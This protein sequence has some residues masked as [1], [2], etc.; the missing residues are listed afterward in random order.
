MNFAKGPCPDNLISDC[1]SIQGVVNFQRGTVKGIRGAEN[2]SVL[3][4]Y[5]N[6]TSDD[7]RPTLS[8][9]DG[10]FLACDHQRP[11]P[12]VVEWKEMISFAKPVPINVTV[13]GG[14]VRFG[15]NGFRAA[16]T[17][18]L[19][20]F[21][22]D[23]HIKLDNGAGSAPVT[24]MVG[25][26]PIIWQK[27]TWYGFRL[28]IDWSETLGAPYNVLMIDRG[29]GFEQVATVE[30]YCS[31]CKYFN[32]IYFYNYD[33]DMIT[34]YDSVRLA[35]AHNMTVKMEVDDTNTSA[36]YSLIYTQG[37]L[38]YAAKTPQSDGCSLNASDLSK[39]ETLVRSTST[40][41]VLNR[42][43]HFILRACAFSNG[44]NTTWGSSRVIYSVGYNAAAKP[45][46]ITDNSATSFHSPG[47]AQYGRYYVDVSSLADNQRVLYALTSRF[48]S[49]TDD[50][51][52][53]FS[54][55]GTSTCEGTKRLKCTGG[56]HSFALEEETMCVKENL[57]M[58]AQ[59][60][61]SGR[62][63]SRPFVSNHLKVRI[64]PPEF[65]Y[66]E[67]VFTHA[68]SVKVKLSSASPGSY[69]VYTIGDKTQDPPT[70]GM[71]MPSY[72]DQID[73]ISVVS[74]V[75]PERGIIHFAGNETRVGKHQLC[76]DEDKF[77]ATVGH[78]ILDPQGQSL[79]AVACRDGNEASANESVFLYIME[80]QVYVL[81]VMAVWFAFFFLIIFIST[82]LGFRSK[83]VAFDERYCNSCGA[84]WCEFL[85]NKIEQFVCSL[86]GPDDDERAN[87]DD[88]DLA[89]FNKWKKA[90]SLKNEQ[91]IPGHQSEEE[92]KLI[93]E[94]SEGGLSTDDIGLDGLEMGPTTSAFSVAS[95]IVDRIKYEVQGNS[96]E[97]F[98]KEMAPH[99]EKGGRIS[100]PDAEQMM[101]ALL[102]P[103]TRLNTKQKAAFDKLHKPLGLSDE[104]FAKFVRTTIESCGSPAPVQDTR[105]A[106]EFCGITDYQYDDYRSPAK[107]SSNLGRTPSSAV[108]DYSEEKGTTTL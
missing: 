58:L 66:P 43:A 11:D 56:D 57:Y 79:T 94:F 100:Q 97:I 69:I 40:E 86:C 88:D 18:A 30:A 48:N 34:Y 47:V 25:G 81:G 9:A 28:Y 17:V 70:C 19:V 22:D 41:V 76:G 82:I 49:Y 13:K 5:K 8:E 74:G 96:Q 6:G 53:Y 55:S 101:Q 20:Y 45:P 67:V 64:Y 103:G 95:K 1:E 12:F 35:D 4:V 60:F 26:K 89:T 75:W 27:D 36:S 3:M 7:A 84:I 107:A 2:N 46:V 90:A 10:A 65:T 32:R 44:T 31:Y 21:D 93:G 85:Y 87:L 42:N 51:A 108:S 83:I 92:K 105:E 50:A 23:Q 16:Q 104:D 15:L 39:G 37:N 14:Y 106:L 63:P 99:L 98:D 24:A 33:A 52:S 80:T 54:S 72:D 59:S 62:W 68:G 29:S 38:S 102:K 78:V 91:L 71:D 77:G 73:D 61:E